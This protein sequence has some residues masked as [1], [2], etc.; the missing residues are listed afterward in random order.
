MRQR[1]FCASMRWHVDASTPALRPRRPPGSRLS[2]P[3]IQPRVLQ[4]FDD[5]AGFVQEDDAPKLRRLEGPQHDFGSPD[6]GVQVVH[7][8][9]DVR[10]MPEL[11]EAKVG[12]I[13]RGHLS[14]SDVLDPLR[15]H[16]RIG[17]PNL[18]ELDSTLAGL[19]FECD[20]ADV[21]K[22]SHLGFPQ[23]R[24]P[25]RAVIP[26]AFRA[27]RIITRRA[28]GDKTCS[29]PSLGLRNRTNSFLAIAAIA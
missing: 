2:E 15:M 27:C 28:A 3:G 19:K 12:W 1:H 13:D 5:G 25:V 17:D 26:D 20:D 16:A 14:R 23:G 10:Q 21:V 22:L 24:S 8:I 11:P 7:A 9:G 29:N 4:Q 6:L 18:T